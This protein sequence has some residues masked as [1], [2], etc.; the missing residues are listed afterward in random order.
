MKTLASAAIM[1]AV[2]IGLLVSGYFLG[3][4]FGGAGHGP[5]WPYDMLDFLGIIP[6][7][8]QNTFWLSI[9]IWLMTPI[10]VALR[11]LRM[12]RPVGIGLLSVLSTGCIAGLVQGDFFVKYFDEL[13]GPTLILWL[14]TGLVFA[15]LVW[16]WLLTFSRTE[17]DIAHRRK[18][19]SFAHQPDCR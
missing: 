7:L 16:L 13:P 2:T 12:M 15:Y 17:S 6:R 5:A 1:I 3:A 14:W 8:H 11:R 4:G 10:V 18:L 19:N 9:A